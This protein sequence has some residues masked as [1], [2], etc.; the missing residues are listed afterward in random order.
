MQVQVASSIMAVRGEQYMCMYAGVGTGSTVVA[1]IVR[2]NV[3]SSPTLWSLDLWLD[4]EGPLLVWLLRALVRLVG[5]C[6]LSS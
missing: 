2:A 3:Q 5:E 4:W 1:K 6:E